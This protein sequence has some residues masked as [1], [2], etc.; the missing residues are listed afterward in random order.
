MDIKRCNGSLFATEINDNNVQTI[1]TP[2]EFFCYFGYIFGYGKGTW[3]RENRHHLQP[4]GGGKYSPLK[5][6]KHLKRLMLTG[7]IAGLQAFRDIKSNCLVNLH[8]E[9]VANFV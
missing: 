2:R 3:D 1:C 6:V 8:Y 5:L 4:G 7:D 9:A